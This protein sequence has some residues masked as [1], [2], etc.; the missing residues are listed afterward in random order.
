MP[1]PKEDRILVYEKGTLLPLSGKE[2]NAADG[3]CYRKRF[4]NG[5]IVERFMPTGLK[6]T[7]AIIVI[8]SEVVESAANTFTDLKVD[9]QLNPLDQEVFVVYGIDLDVVDPTLVPGTT[10]A[11]NLSLS[12][13]QRTNVGGMENS[14]VL[15]NNRIQI[16]SAGGEVV[17]GAYASDSAPG[18]QLE[19]VGIIATNDFYLNIIGSNNTLARFGKARVYGVRAKASSAIYAALVQ[20]ELLSA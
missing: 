9:L 5:R 6:E 8:S 17:R 4:I 2:L 20:S 16:Q 1:H 10:T 13:T 19:Y 3:L 14:N 12:T 7:S 18:T 11:I 15:A